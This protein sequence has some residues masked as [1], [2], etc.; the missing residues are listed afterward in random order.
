M[1]NS[2][3]KCELFSI[4][5]IG[6]FSQAFGLRHR[7]GDR[8][9]LSKITLSDGKRVVNTTLF[10]SSVLVNKIINVQLSPDIDLSNVFAFQ[11]NC[12]HIFVE[13][14]RIFAITV[15]FFLFF[16]RN[17]NIVTKISP[18]KSCETSTKCFPY[19]TQQNRKEGRKKTHRHTPVYHNQ[20]T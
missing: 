7:N 6:E 20:Y 13:F 9:H 5:R 19:C 11:L 16:N 14:C 8:I 10:F 4:T 3:M 17:F 12:K 1:T 18:V 15:I 2:E